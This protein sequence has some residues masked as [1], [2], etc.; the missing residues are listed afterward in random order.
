MELTEQQ[1]IDVEEYGS[2]NHSPRDIAIL[3]HIDIR[4]L[5]KEFKDL[6]SET[7]IA[8]DRGRLKTDT[9]LRKKLRDE[10][11]T[12]ITAAQE[13]NKLKYYDEINAVKDSLDDSM[14]QSDEHTLKVTYKDSLDHYHALD[15]FIASNTDDS[16]LPEQLQ[17]YWL[18]L[19]TAHDLFQKFY[20]RSKGKKHIAKMLKLKYPGI[21]M[22]TA[23]RYISESVNFFNVSL[24]KEQ[25]RNVLSEDLEK[26][27]AVGWQMNRMDYVIKAIEAQGKIQNADKDDP[28]NIPEELLQQKTIIITMDPKELGVEPVSRKELKDRI[29]NWDLSQDQ[30]KDLMDDADIV[31]EVDYEEV[32]DGSESK[33][34]ISE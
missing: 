24:T 25:W 30:K 15:E 9:E 17:E 27:K 13:F 33:K 18:R 22:A 10:S 31:E 5:E 21:S 28:E 29:N 2:I 16:P 6:N 3:L 1:L 23:F 32:N 34:D 26:V 11:K 7:R 8:Y 19:S 12:S 20:N 4:E 14:P